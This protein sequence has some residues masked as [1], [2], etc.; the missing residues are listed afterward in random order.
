MI[1]VKVAGTGYYVPEK[2]LDNAYFES[3][4]DTSDEWILTRTGIKE[5]RIAAPEQATSDLSI[6]ASK[7][8]IAASG[9]DVSDIDFVIHHSVT[10][11]MIYPGTSNIVQHALGIKGAGTLDTQAGCTGFIYALSIGYAYIKAGMYKNVLVAAGDCLTRVTDYQDRGTCVLFGDGAAAFVLSASDEDKFKGF[12]LDGD[13][14]YQDFISQ[15]VGGSRM[16][17]TVENIQNRMQYLKMAGQNTF[18][19]AVGAMRD[20]VLHVLKQSGLE[21]KD[22]D[23]IIPHQANLRIMDAVAK[24]LKAPKEKLVKTIHKYGNSSATT[25][26]IAFGD[27]LEAGKIKRGDKVVFVA[28]GAGATW[29]ATVFEY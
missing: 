11:D 28:F 17:P 6:E 13:G 27:Y 3:I 5:R 29:G 8:A 20:S 12:Y 10:P 9:L 21:A 25:L 24:F 2:V 16:P 1:G 7:K 18:K 26:G 23:W 19:L 22:I 15:P 14:L 4:V